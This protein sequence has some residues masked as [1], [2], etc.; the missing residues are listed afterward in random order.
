MALSAWF[1]KTFISDRIPGGTTNLKALQKYHLLLQTVQKR[2]SAA[3]CPLTEGVARC[4]SLADF[5]QIWLNSK[6]FPVTC[7]SA[8]EIFRPFPRLSFATAHRHRSLVQQAQPRPPLPCPGDFPAIRPA[9]QIVTDRVLKTQRRSGFLAAVARLDVDILSRQR[10][11]QRCMDAPVTFR[12]TPPCQRFTL[13]CHHR[14]SPVS[15]VI[16]DSPTGPAAHQIHAR[17][18]RRRPGDFAEI[19]DARPL[20]RPAI[21]PQ[22]RDFCRFKQPLVHRHRLRPRA[23]DRV[24]PQQ[25]FFKNLHPPRVS[26]AN[27]ETEH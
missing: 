9:A 22:H 17:K 1:S 26:A 19:A 24:H 6:N 8:R 27:R 20:T 23:P 5:S 10:F 15:P 18:C 7:H 14:V 4:D 3:A 11:R 16:H 25:Q 12:P 13:R 2:P 21:D